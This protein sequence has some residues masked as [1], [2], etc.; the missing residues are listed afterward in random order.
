MK[1][2]IAALASTLAIVGAT[3]LPIDEAAAQDVTIRVSTPEFGV[4]IGAPR[5]YEPPVVVAPA[6]VYQ[7]AV[8]YPPAPRVIYAPAPRVIYAPVYERGWHR[9]HRHGHRAHRHG[10]ER[11][12]D[13][14][15]HDRDY[16][17]RDRDHD[18]DGRRYR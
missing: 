16:D 6:P 1:I 11:D 17:R 15:R 4:R 9:H 10:W 7:P 12:H 13:H 18:R 8:V 14:D 5:H 3:L 2:R